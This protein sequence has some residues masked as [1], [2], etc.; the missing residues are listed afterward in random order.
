MILH[1]LVVCMTGLC[2][3]G[4]S[5]Q[6]LAQPAQ[7]PPPSNVEVS[8][9]R[10]AAVVP[11]VPVTG[12]VHSQ[13]DLQITVAVDGQLAFVA[14]PG[15]RVEMGDALVTLD[16]APLNLQRAEQ[17]ALIKRAEA[18]LA[19]LDRQLGRQRDL[20]TRQSTAANQLD[21]TQLDRDVAASDLEV[22]RLRMA[23]LDDQLARSE[24]RAQFDGVV[25][26]RLRREGESVAR[27][28]PVARVTDTS[29]LEVRVQVPLRIAGALTPGLALDVYGYELVATGRVRSLVPALDNRTQA[30]ELRVEISQSSRPWNIGELVSVLVPQ[31]Q[32]AQELVVDRDA[33][34]LRREGTFVFR[35]TPAQTVERVAVTTGSSQ[36]NDI[37]IRGALN[38][39]DDLVIRG[40]ETLREGQSVN[41]VDGR[42]SMLSG[43]SAMR[44]SGH[45]Q[46]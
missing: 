37:A 20:M 12:Y 44:V 14:E 3:L 45:C 33:L 18:Q 7:D 6:V 39:G 24:V 40:A 32:P 23:Q 34:V 30:M 31:A 35:V 13:N 17:A 46:K 4:V 36:G 11:T 22:A 25:T 27:G 9:V 43:C 15:T 2:L 21:Q 41:V 8:S 5:G 19:F 1:K 29:A 26:D 28:T 42:A 16:V 38:E 10:L